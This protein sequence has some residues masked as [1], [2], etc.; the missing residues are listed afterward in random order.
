MPSPAV[1][2]DPL[3]RLFAGGRHLRLVL[4][5]R[6]PPGL[7]IPELRHFERIARLARPGQAGSGGVIAD[8]ARL[9][10]HEAVFDR[11]LVTTPL[12]KLGARAELREIWRILAPA[13]LALLV[14]RARRPWQLAVPGW[15]Q[16]GLATALDD[17]M[18]EVLAS[19]VRTLPD[20]HHL[21]LV[22][23][24]DGLK[25]ALVGR[26]EAAA[27]VAATQG[28]STTTCKEPQ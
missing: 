22:G 4:A 2:D 12:P 17:A 9:P 13:G 7:T 25:P 11:A 16:D 24:R 3:A 21:V 27:P 19:Q 10:F 20:R 18:F 8:P 28:L 15:T 1:A 5:G 14:V 23:K 6:T 26:V